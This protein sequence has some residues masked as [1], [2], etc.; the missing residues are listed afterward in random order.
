MLGR[1]ILQRYHSYDQFDSLLFLYMFYLPLDTWI[2]H[3]IR[4]AGTSLEIIFMVNL[5]LP[6]ELQAH[7]N[8][9]ES[10]CAI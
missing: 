8:F 5:R 3:M 1:Y 4:S 7:A 9:H 2:L 10:L 6:V